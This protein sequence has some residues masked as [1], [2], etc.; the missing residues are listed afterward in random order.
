MNCSNTGSHGSGAIANLNN[1]TVEN[2]KLING[3]G[4]ATNSIDGGNN[5]GWVFDTSPVNSDLYWIG[6]SGN[7]SDPNH[8][9]FSSGIN[10]N[11][12]S[13]L[14]NPL[15]NT[16]FNADSGFNEN[17]NKIARITRKSRLFKSFIKT[18][19]M[20]NAIKATKI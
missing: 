19:Y 1:F 3:S 6:G 5:E 7:W 9:S 13:C 8:W 20:N 15:T 11:P 2:I 16:F 4:L 12:N 10:N 14:P 17:S 18:D